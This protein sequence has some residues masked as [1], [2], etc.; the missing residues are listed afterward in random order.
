MREVCIQ[1]V[2]FGL[3]TATVSQKGFRPIGQTIRIVP[4]VVQKIGTVGLLVHSENSLEL[5]MKL[6]E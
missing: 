2:P 5:L 3:S 6:V 1:G 4:G